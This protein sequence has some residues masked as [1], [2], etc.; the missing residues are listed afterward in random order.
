MKKEIYDN[1]TKEYSFLEDYEQE[2][3]NMKKMQKIPQKAQQANI[4]PTPNIQNKKYLNNYQ[5]QQ[6]EIK[7]EDSQLSEIESA[8][9]KYQQTRYGKFASKE[10]DVSK[11][12]DK[13]YLYEN[14]EIKKSIDSQTEVN[15]IQDKEAFEDAVKAIKKF[16]F[17][18]YAFLNKEFNILNKK[19]IRCSMICYDDPKLFT[20]NEAKICAENCH[21]NIRNAAKF[22]ENLQEKNKTKLMECIEKAREFKEENLSEDKVTNFFKCYD[23]LIEDFSTME[24]EMKREFSYYI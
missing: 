18:F 10:L 23:N 19:M 11:L 20:V 22:A 16:E 12:E 14:L 2:Y 6:E 15:E 13:D 8:K 17:R 3:A 21:Q 5:T 24:K 4:A 9:Q 7:Q 1:I